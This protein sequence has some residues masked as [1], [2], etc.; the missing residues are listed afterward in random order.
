MAIPKFEDFLFPFMMHLTNQDSN[1][2][3]MVSVLSDFFN[4]SEE[5]KQQKTKGGTSYQIYDRIGWSLQWLRRAKFV[6]IP[7]KGIWRI[8]Q[9]GRDYMRNATDLRESDLLKYPEF[10]EYSGR[11]NERKRQ[12][13][14]PSATTTSA[15]VTHNENWKEIVEVL[16]SAIEEASSFLLYVNS[17][18]SCLRL[19]GWKKSNGTIQI[20]SNNRV[21]EQQ[22][23]FLIH[24]NDKRPI[25]C[26]VTKNNN[27]DAIVSRADSIASYLDGINKCIGILFVECIEIFFQNTEDNKPTSIA[28]IELDNSVLLGEVL[29]NLLEYNTFNYHK[30]V[31]FC[32]QQFKQVPN[33]T[34][35]LNRVQE[36]AADT[37]FISSKIKEV[38]L[39]EGYEESLISRVLSPLSFKIKM[40]LKEQQNV[41]IEHENNVSGKHD[42][43]K[44]SLDGKAYLNKRAF[45][46]AVIKR[47]VN[48]HPYTTYEEL[49]SQFPSETHS[50][51]R[52]VIRPL[53][54]VNDWIKE[55]PDLKKRYFLSPDD[56]IQLHDG[57]RVVVNN[58]WGTHFPKFLKIA[59]TLYSVQSDQ[60]YSG[61][62]DA[63]NSNVEQGNLHGIRIS[64][65]SFS[66][67]NNK[68]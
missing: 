26:I 58:Q 44:F 2:S 3:D 23:I 51:K 34:N 4:L 47:F 40:K 31:T 65:D 30:L 64:A 67:F 63:D 33:E 19:L 66:K 29:C 56:I 21:D 22:C 55:N 49:E 12:R 1:K 9:R 50:K 32:I 59:Q 25:P 28:S 41:K 15:I 35:L 8:T 42:N 7:E 46:L 27:A 54:V 52:G 13:L 11:R 43:T 36:V 17:V 48:E 39:S 60:P 14:S 16:R 53:N 6:E 68:K 5:D 61:I 18:I 37:D 24:E 45:V 38:L 57:T 20:E 10:A 62:D